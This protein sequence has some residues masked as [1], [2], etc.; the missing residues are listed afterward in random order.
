MWTSTSR[1]IKLT[2]LCIL[3][4]GSWRQQIAKGE[5]IG[6]RTRSKVTNWKR[7][8]KRL[9]FNYKFVSPHQNEGKRNICKVTSGTTKPIKTAKLSKTINSENWNDHQNEQSKIKQQFEELFER[10]GK[11]KRHKVGIEFEQNT[12]KTQQKGRRVPIQ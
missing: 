7:L 8:F 1:K 6:S 11:I 9:A 12:K 3:S 4:I 2:G 5:N 10:Q